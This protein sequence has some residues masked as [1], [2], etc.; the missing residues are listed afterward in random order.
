MLEGLTR[1]GAQAV[2]GGLYGHALKCYDEAL[3]MDPTNALLYSNRAV[4]GIL[5]KR[6]EEALEDAEKAIEY[7]KSWSRVSLFWEYIIA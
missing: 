7:Q 5:L 6:Y 4:V 3:V 2:K 1:E